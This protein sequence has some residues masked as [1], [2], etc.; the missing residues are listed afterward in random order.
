MAA[1]IY[2]FYFSFVVICS[3]IQ[4][5]FYIIKKNLIKK[6]NIIIEIVLFW[7]GIALVCYF[8]YWAFTAKK[9]FYKHIG[10]ASWVILIMYIITAI[11]EEIKRKKYF[12]PQNTIPLDKT[13]KINKKSNK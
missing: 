3:L 13:K 5:H 8:L 4:I 11:Y 2:L 9:Y 7:N 6:I 10:P 1:V 12:K